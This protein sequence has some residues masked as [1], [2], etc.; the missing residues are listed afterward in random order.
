MLASLF[1][2]AHARYTSLPV[3]GGSLEGLCVWLHARGYPRDAIGRRMAVEEGLYIDDDLLQGIRDKNISISMGVRDAL[4]EWFK[5]ETRDEDYDSLEH[6][7]YNTISIKGKKAW[8][9]LREERDRKRRVSWSISSYC[10]KS[11]SELTNT[12]TAC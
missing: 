4:N 7:L 9:E 6:F 2:R 11:T 1:P 12:V 5:R 10:A 3:L 8:K